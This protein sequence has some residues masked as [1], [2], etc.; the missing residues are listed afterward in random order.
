MFLQDELSEKQISSFFSFDFC[1]IMRAPCDMNEVSTP[2][3]ELKEQGNR[4]GTE[5]WQESLPF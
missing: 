3:V 5:K 4:E 1:A 2:A